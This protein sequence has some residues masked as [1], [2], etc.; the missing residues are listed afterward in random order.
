MQ[1]VLDTYQKG[2]ISKSIISVH[3]KLKND[4]RTHM[5]GSYIKEEIPLEISIL[6][7]GVK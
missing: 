3:I 4:D 2:H 1:L 7:N 5:Y 6:F